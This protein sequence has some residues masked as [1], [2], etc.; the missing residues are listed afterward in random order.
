MKRILLSGFCLLCVCTLA[1]ARGMKSTEK[2]AS[3]GD[4]EQAIEDYAKEREEKAHQKPELVRVRHEDDQIIIELKNTTE[5]L[6]CEDN[7]AHHM[8]T[9]SEPEH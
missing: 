1:Q 7:I 5:T 6:F 2:F 3:H 4:C 8:V 9:E